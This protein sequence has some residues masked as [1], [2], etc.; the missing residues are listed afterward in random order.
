MSS[1]AT[2]SPVY[3]HEFEWNDE[4]F[5]SGRV[6]KVSPKTKT[7]WPKALAAQPPSRPVMSGDCPTTP[8]SRAASTRTPGRAAGQA[9]AG[10]SRKTLH[11]LKRSP[12]HLYGD[13]GAPPGQRPQ[14]AGFDLQASS[15]ATLPLGRASHQRWIDSMTR[16]RSARAATATWRR[17]VSRPTITG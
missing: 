17:T 10:N 9:A 1:A 8:T 13:D 7:S 14:F 6:T 4:P 12:V 16:C 11:H 5:T 3:D 15:K 2:R